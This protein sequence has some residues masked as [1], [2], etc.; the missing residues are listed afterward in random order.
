MSHTRVLL[1]ASPRFSHFV[2][3]IIHKT[4]S[5]LAIVG[6]TTDLESALVLI[7]AQQPDILLIDIYPKSSQYLENIAEI[8]AHYPHLHII[9]RTKPSKN[10]LFRQAIQVGVSGF[11]NEQ[12]S[13][14]ELREAIQTVQ[15]G[16]A[17]LPP[18]LAHQFVL[19]L[20]RQPN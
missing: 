16:Y 11:I 4:A 7:K 20:Q 12:A 18:N 17:Y 5:N 15:Q 3:N 14:E 13:L 1:L 2:K 6:V 8:R 9:G 10:G 19:G